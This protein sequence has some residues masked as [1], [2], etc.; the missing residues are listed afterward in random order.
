MKPCASERFPQAALN[1]MIRESG[2][3][4][5]DDGHTD[6]YYAGLLLAALRAIADD[7]RDGDEWVSGYDLC[8][9]IGARVV[10]ALREE[11]KT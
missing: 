8:V 2:A 10:A 7:A 4:Q 11:D 5:H 9:R 3:P 6:C 1:A